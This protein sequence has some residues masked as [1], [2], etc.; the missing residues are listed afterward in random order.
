MKHEGFQEVNLK[1]LEAH[2]EVIPSEDKLIDKSYKSTKADNA[3]R[4]EVSAYV[5]N[6][7]TH[8]QELLRGI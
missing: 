8:T 2:M 7:R 1:L 3:L 5:T 6:R 4:E